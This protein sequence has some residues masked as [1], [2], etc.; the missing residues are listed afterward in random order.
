[1]TSRTT[2]EFRKS[3]RGLHP[4]VQKQA[5][6]AY[7]TWLRD[8]W[9]PSLRFKQIHPN[10]IYSVRI[11]LGW[12]AVGARRDDMLLWYWIGSHNDYDNLIQGLR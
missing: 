12:R 1:M 11:A 5:E 2:K 4:H 8:P 3:L 7:R 9:H 10:A 6:E